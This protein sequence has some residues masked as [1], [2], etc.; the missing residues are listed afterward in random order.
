MKR[1][2]RARQPHH[3]HPQLDQRAGDHRMELPE[4]D[5]RLGTGQVRLRDRDL[6]LVQAQLGAT[7]G[8]IPRHRHLRQR[9]AMLGD[10]PLPHPPGSMPLLPRHALVRH[11]PPVDDLR[12]RANRR[13]RPRRINL[14][15]RRHRARQRL[16]HRPPVHVMLCSQLPYRQPASPLVPPDLLKQLHPRP[17][18]PRPPRRQQRRENQNQGGAKIRDDTPPTTQRGSPPRRGQDSRRKPA[19]PGPVQVTTL[20]AATSAAAAVAAVL[21]MRT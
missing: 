15:R 11:Q 16:A 3:E 9:G 20:N 2:P 12:I 18:H 6:D 4:V 1:P 14:P 17:R 10:Q 8:D 19:Q 5:L 21:V 7:A 13:A